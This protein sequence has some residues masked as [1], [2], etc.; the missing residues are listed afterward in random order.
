MLDKKLPNP[1]FQGYL[2]HRDQTQ[3]FFDSGDLSMPLILSLI[4]DSD[5]IA[6]LACI[7]NKI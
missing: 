2:E 7:N 5:P 6:I 4:H 3:P 1:P